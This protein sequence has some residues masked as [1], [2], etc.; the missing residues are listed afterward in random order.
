MHGTTPNRLEHSPVV[1]LCSS[2]AVGS[3]NP[4]YPCKLS[5][6]DLEKPNNGKQQ[7]TPMSKS[8]LLISQALILAWLA[9]ASLCAGEALATKVS[10]PP[11]PHESDLKQNAAAQQVEPTASRFYQSNDF[12]DLA[13][14]KEDA[15]AKA[16][17]QAESDRKQSIAELKL[18]ANQQLTQALAANNRA[19]QLGKLGHWLEAIAEHEKAVQL[20]P[21][22]KQYRINLSAAQVTLADVQLTAGDAAGCAQL[23][24]Q[25]LTVAPDNGLAG[26]KL[27]A[28][29]TKMGL[30]PN[31]ATV[32]LDLADQ[33]VK[34]NDLSAAAIE[35]QAAI[36]LEDSERTYTKM[37][38]FAYR[39]GQISVANSWYKQALVKNANYGLAHRQ[40]GLIAYQQGDLTNAAA[41]LRKA[42]IADPKDATAADA[43]VGLWRKQVAANSQIA[44]NHLGLACALQLSG[45]LLAADSEYGQVESLSP[46]NPQ[47]IAGRASLK[48][49][50][51]HVLAE[52]HISA[53]E[54]LYGQNLRKEALT[55]ISQAVMLEPRNAHYQF[56]LG[57]CLE[58]NGD[59]PGANQAYLT[60]VLIDPENN[61]EA[62]ARM[63]QMQ[64]N[65]LSQLSI[66]QT[67]TSMAGQSINPINQPNNQTLETNLSTKKNPQTSNTLAPTSAS[68]T[69]QAI[70]EQVEQ[71]E[72]S[73]NYR[74]AADQLKQILPQHLADFACH[75][76][77]AVNLL[78]A[79]DVSEAISEFR[80]ASALCPTKKEYADDL[81]NA[82][83]IAKT[84]LKETS[85]PAQDIPSASQANKDLATKGA[86]LKGG[87]Q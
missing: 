16:A 46:G 6:I 64:I 38:D 31:S 23:C 79:G 2:S 75:H 62:A 17:K 81:S 63:K 15:Q 22:N 54:I 5:C 7:L 20:D 43:L 74:L 83:A 34:A 30:D 48:Q 18:K 27:V 71:A 1:K 78:N 36:Q 73:R 65:G 61:K 86:A 11:L 56:L 47:L 9:S 40:L 87:N 26:R 84:A 39:L 70:L 32:R 49:A 60:C 66:N 82:I 19:V 45:D 76:R 14:Q 52:K 51:Q 42:V 44:E 21:S 28:A 25:A 29:L 59:Y 53:A 57:E 69:D 72:A 50:R 58:A 12:R 37:G 85:M 24:R 67:S 4:V 10:A 35:Y 41:E 3:A 80:I 68:K 77:L 13:K 8:A 55:Q 33:L